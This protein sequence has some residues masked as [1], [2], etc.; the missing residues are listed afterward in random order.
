MRHL[1]RPQR[2]R[3]FFGC[4]GISEQS[5]GTFL[6]RLVDHKHRFHIDPVP[7]GGGDPLAIVERAFKLVRARERDFGKRYHARAVLLDRDKLGLAP[8]RDA[9][10]QGL[11][12]A[13][14]MKAIWQSPSH[15]G[16][17]LRHIQG[18]EHQQPATS[19]LAAQRI[20]QKWPDYEKGKPASYLHARLDIQAVERAC[21]VEQ[22]LREFLNQINFFR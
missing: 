8:N 13:G 5:Y 10:I 21:T 15:E 3:I 12:Y 17:L 22:D 2:L 1:M 14:K 6:H 9:K 4:E 19:A 16:L 7:L 18:C 11:L 20:R